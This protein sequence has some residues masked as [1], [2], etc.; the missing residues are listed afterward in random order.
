[1]H[2]LCNVLVFSNIV[3]IIE[4]GVF[5]QNIASLSKKCDV[6]RDVLGFKWGGP[7]M[8]KMFRIFNINDYV[9]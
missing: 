8:L 1:M 7:T 5:F 4:V 9:I 2:R 3:K 6:L